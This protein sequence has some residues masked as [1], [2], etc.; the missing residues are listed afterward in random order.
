VDQLRIAAFS[1]PDSR[2]AG[3]ALYE[4]I[5]V[6]GAI[7]DEKMALKGDSPDDKIDRRIA[8]EYC[9][10]FL[11]DYPTSPYGPLVAEKLFR[12]TAAMGRQQGMQAAFD[13][14]LVNYPGDR[15]TTVVALDYMNYYAGRGRLDEAEKVAAAAL[16]GGSEASDPEALVR[17][18]DSLRGWGFR[19]L[20]R[21]AYEQ[22]LV[23]VRAGKAELGQKVDPTKDARTDA[24]TLAARGRL[25]QIGAQAQAGLD[26]LDAP[27]PAPAAATRPA[28]GPPSPGPGGGS[29]PG[30]GA[31]PSPRRRP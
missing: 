19:D 2:W 7:V 13:A 22:T 26:Q 8:L 31:A 3:H 20:A 11:R 16:R 6:S 12:M 15:A 21:R 5:R 17:M 30:G 29:G 14:L 18:G 25:R 23:A 1:Y 24:R 4:L 27:P 28:A 9:R 10:Q